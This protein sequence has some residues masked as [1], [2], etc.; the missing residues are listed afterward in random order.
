MATS[1]DGAWKVGPDARTV[2]WRLPK[3]GPGCM[4]DGES[5]LRES[6]VIRWTKELEALS[7]LDTA[8]MLD[9][10][11][12]GRMKYAEAEPL[13]TWQDEGLR[14]RDAKRRAPSKIRLPAAVGRTVSLDERGA[15]PETR[16]GNGI[17]SYRQA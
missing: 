14:S 4:T 6:V 13:T 8:S 5:A 17:A 12:L 16:G 2:V 7:P 10:S 3:T 11:R 1:A 9:E 15:T